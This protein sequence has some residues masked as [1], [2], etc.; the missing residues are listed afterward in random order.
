MAPGGELALS[1]DN[2]ADWA[3]LSR[4]QSSTGDVPWLAWALDGGATWMSV[5][6]IAFDPVVP[7]R[8]WLAE[9]TGIWYADLGDSP[10]QVHWLS[11]TR[12]IENLVPTG[13]V[14]PPGGKPLL[15]AWD[16]PVFRSEDPRTYPTHY[17]PENQF[18]SAW[19]IDWA[20]TDPDY[21]VADV[22]SH[23]WPSDPSTS[24]YSEDGGKTWTP[25]PS[26]PLH[27]T[28]AV[29][30]FGFGAMAVS[31]PGNI[32][33]VPAF[34]KRPEY[35]LDGGKTWAVVVLPGLSDYSLVDNRPYYVNRQVIAADKAT[36]G[37][38]YLYVLDTGVYRS[39][40]GGRTWALRSDNTPMSHADF[41]WSATLKAVPSHGGELY[42]TPGRLAGTVTQPFLHS[43]DGGK[44]WSNVRGVTGVTAFGFG[45]PFPG[46]SSPALY[47]AGYV[48]GRYGVYRSLDDRHSWTHLAEYP[49]GRTAPIIA[50]DG[51]KT[52]AGRVYLAVEGNGWIYRGSAT[53]DQ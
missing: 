2:G 3:T 48:H 14:V 36:S 13:V 1:Q 49:G 31:A 7:G 32:V 47:I 18:G 29:T 34:G 40:D 12:G 30:T 39:T 8:L 26:I 4:R 22:A 44:T 35:T 25:F 19:S 38:F 52:I 23:Q 46:S 42:L 9:G 37:T 21:V 43:T 53:E 11:Q 16:R 6:E 24:G 17:G 28:N 5:G 45:R 15:T 41:G 27:S 51:D 20:V 33:W 50:M 10:T